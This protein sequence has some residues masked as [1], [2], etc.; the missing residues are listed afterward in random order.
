MFLALPRVRIVVAEYWTEPQKMWKIISGIPI[1]HNH[2]IQNFI[3]FMNVFKRNVVQH[4][5]SFVCVCVCVCLRLFWLIIFRCMFNAASSRARARVWNV[6]EKKHEWSTGCIRM[7]WWYAQQTDF[8][9]KIVR[10]MM[11]RYRKLG[12]EWERT[13]TCCCCCTGSG[14]SLLWLDEP[15]PMPMMMI[16][17]LLVVLADGTT[18]TEASDNQ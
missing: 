1:Q 6:Q 11:R 10:A 3:R 4:G 9:K 12:H 14:D 5:L 16:K 17:H 15:R 8:F 7:H 18:T 13:R 2:T